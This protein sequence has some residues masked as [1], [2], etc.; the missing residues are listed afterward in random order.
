MS[1]PGYFLSLQEIKFIAAVWKC[2][3]C[4]YDYSEVGS[5]QERFKLIDSSDFAASDVSAKVVLVVQNAGMMRGHYSRLFSAE[6]WVMHDTKIQ[7]KESSSSHSSYSSSDDDSSDDETSSDHDST[8]NATKNDLKKSADDKTDSACRRKDAS[9]R[10]ETRKSEGNEEE[11]TLSSASETDHQHRPRP[12]KDEAA[13][14]AAGTSTTAN[15]EEDGND[16]VMEVDSLSD[17]SDDSDLFHVSHVPSS[18]PRTREDKD[19]QIINSIA[20]HLRRYPLLPCDG[21]DP[22]K[23]RDFTDVNSGQRLPLL[24][25]GFQ[26]CSWTSEP[27]WEPQLHWDREQKLFV[28]LR[29]K[30]RYVEMKEVPKDTWETNSKWNY[31]FDPLAYYKNIRSGQVPNDPHSYWSGQTRPA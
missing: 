9:Q 24:H 12:T 18:V 10:S 16:E 17:I 5:M 28:H 23:M 30:H 13:T 22:N 1:D 8:A 25:C 6:D 27:G 21:T 2:N 15:A 4:V 7:G 3:L 20:K 14:G 29:E 31:H 26:G 11:S 19:L